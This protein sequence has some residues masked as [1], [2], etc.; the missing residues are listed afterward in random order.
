MKN[1]GS[2]KRKKKILSL[3]NR[4]QEMEERIISDIEDTIAEM[5]TSMKENVKFK[6]YPGT[7]VPGNL[8]HCG[9]KKSLQIKIVEGEETQVQVTKIIFQ[10]NHRRKFY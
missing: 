6:K 5:D 3:T 8:G 1:L 7:K 2:Q 9:E 10:K 4:G